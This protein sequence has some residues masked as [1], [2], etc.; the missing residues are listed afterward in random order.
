MSG[1]YTE[2]DH[3]I[4]MSTSCELRT[5]GTELVVSLLKIR[6][7]HIKVSCYDVSWRLQGIS[8]RSSSRSSGDI[9]FGL[10][11]SIADWRAEGAWTPLLDPIA[12]RC[13]DLP[14]PVAEAESG[15]LLA[16]RRWCAE[17]GAGKLSFLSIAWTERSK[18]WKSDS[19]RVRMGIRSIV[20]DSSL[21]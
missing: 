20:L 7:H 16:G 9:T 15:V 5:I 8:L 3:K 11:L 2:V 12:G 17:G 19:A 1:Q 4:V 6:M 21:T 10:S 13:G 14:L 18:R